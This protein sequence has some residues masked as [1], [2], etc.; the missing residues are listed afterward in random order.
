MSKMLEE[1][2]QL[3]ISD[4][5]QLEKLIT[6]CSDW[7]SSEGFDNWKE[8][9]TSEIIMKKLLNSIVYG[10]FVGKELIGC[11]S[12][13]NV[14]PVY[15]ISEDLKYYTFQDKNPTHLS[16]LAVSPKYQ[17]QG[18]ATKLLEFSEKLARKKSKAIR[19]DVWKKNLDLNK[20]YIKRGYVLVPEISAKDEDIN[21]Y[22]KIVK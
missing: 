16:M 18:L 12:I 17:K 14:M 7:L 10:L 19:L 13:S 11:I 4:F 20:F 2:R 9:Y 1:L 8:Y 15:S 3:N 6:S 5:N 21:Y 22:E